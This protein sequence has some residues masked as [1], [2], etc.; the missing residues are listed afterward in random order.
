ME[1]GGKEKAG[2]EPSFPLMVHHAL[3]CSVL[4]RPP[5]PDGLTPL[6]LS[7]V[8]LSSLKLL[9]SGIV[10]EK[11]S[12]DEDGDLTKEYSLF[13]HPDHVVSK[14]GKILPVKILAREHEI[15]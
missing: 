13:W 10:S 2:G 15:G 6:E 1:K 9:L 5:Y 3:G 8:T 4:P 12:S 14:W 11:Y 7:K